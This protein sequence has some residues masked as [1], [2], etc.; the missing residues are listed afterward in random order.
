[1]RYSNVVD[2]QNLIKWLNNLR[3]L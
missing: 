2:S 1:V 3:Y